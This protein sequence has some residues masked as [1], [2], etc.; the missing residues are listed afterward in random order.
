MRK[1]VWETNNQTN[2]HT[3]EGSNFESMEFIKLNRSNA[4]KLKEEEEI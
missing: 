2:K 3:S 1:T 4:M